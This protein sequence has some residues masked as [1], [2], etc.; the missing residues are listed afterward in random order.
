MISI[1]HGV[2][3]EP[4]FSAAAIVD[5]VAPTPLAAIHS[6]Q[7]EFVP[8]SEARKVLAAAKE[9]KKLWIVTASGHAFSDNL[10]EFD[11]RL[12]EAIAWVTANAAQ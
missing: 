11:R 8:L 10:P 12:I 4:T 1:T 6:T 7:D 9:P 2:P 3:K 5:R